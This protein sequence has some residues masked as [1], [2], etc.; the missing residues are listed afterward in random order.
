MTGL[1]APAELASLTGNYSKRSFSSVAPYLLRILWTLKSARKSMPLQRHLGRRRM[2]WWWSLSLLLLLSRRRFVCSGQVEDTTTAQLE[3]CRLDLAAADTNSTDGYLTL[4]EYETFVNQRYYV[5]CAARVS[6]AQSVS[7]WQAFTQLA[8]FTCLEEWSANASSTALTSLPDCCLPFNNSRIAIYGLKSSS[9]SDV[10][11]WLARTCDTADAAAV[12]DQCY[13]AR[14]IAT[15]A[16][17]LSSPSLAPIVVLGGGSGS[18]SSDSDSDAIPQSA[19]YTDC[20][21][22]LVTADV[23]ASGTLNRVEFDALLQLHALAVMATS[24]TQAATETAT[25]NNNNNGTTVMVSCVVTKLDSV[26]TAAYAALVCASCSWHGAA[27]ATTTTTTALDISCCT[28]G[29]SENDNTGNISILGAASPMALRTESERAWIRRLCLAATA[30]VECT[31]TTS[32]SGTNSPLAS[33]PVTAPVP[34]SSST[35]NGL[36]VTVNGTMPVSSPTV[37]NGTNATASTTAAPPAAIPV[38][39]PTMNATT[40][41][42]FDINGTMTNTTTMANVSTAPAPAMVPPPGGADASV[43]AATSTTQARSSGVASVPL[44]AWGWWW[45]CAWTVLGLYSLY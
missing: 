16:A 25:S 37:S 43:A 3:Q 40:S 44:V 14:P 35:T 45:R 4:W 21:A 11:S 31:T 41:A 20:S 22:D 7:Q 18:G 30:L 6:V 10:N 19:L 28:S 9:S 36:N 23:D 24:I 5:N 33:P 26:V 39:A 38:L 8:C 2:F 13:T 1:F 17:P 32:A 29:E 27:T 34:I 15:V 42:M 12:A